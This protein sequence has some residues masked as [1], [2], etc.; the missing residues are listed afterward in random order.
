MKNLP[1]VLWMIGFPL[2]CNIN[3]C[4][5]FL[6]DKKQSDKAKRLLAVI[7]FAVWICVGCLMYEK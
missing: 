3:N 1:F 4:F 7:F 2:S 5:L 6:K